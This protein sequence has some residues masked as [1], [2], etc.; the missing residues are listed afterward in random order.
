M[1]KLL[2]LLPLILTAPVLAESMGEYAL[3][4]Y[5]RHMRNADKFFELVD[6]QMACS[7]MRLASTVLRVYFSDLQDELP[8]LDWFEQRQLV[9]G[10][11][12]DSCTPFGY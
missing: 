4:Q 11:I 1:R 9:E 10:A 2:L 8:N 5:E 3:K 12:A 7:E 6:D